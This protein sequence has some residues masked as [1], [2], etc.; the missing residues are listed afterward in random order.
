MI[1]AGCLELQAVLREKLGQQDAKPKGKCR[2]WNSAKR[3]RILAQRLA[4]AV[5]REAAWPSITVGASRSGY[6]ITSG[7]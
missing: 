2:C 3:S 1:S 7:H 4:G 5:P 6:A